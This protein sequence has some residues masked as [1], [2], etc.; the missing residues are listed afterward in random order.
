MDLAEVMTELGGRGVS[1]LLVEGGGKL[2]G[3]LLERSLV[4]RLIVAHAPVLIGAAGRPA[5]SLAG[6]E[7]L[8]EAP[9]FD[10]EW[11]RRMGPDTVVSYRC[12][13]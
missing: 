1:S 5:V 3:A 7:T 9:R 13:E 11:S 4:H 6:P 2:A 8:A 10:V 12:G